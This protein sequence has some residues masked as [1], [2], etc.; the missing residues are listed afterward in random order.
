MPFC[1]CPLRSGSSGN[2]LFVQAGNTR[3][4]VDAGLSGRTVEQA[5]T[6]VG[7]SPDSL[8]AILVSHEHA[9]HIRG[10]GVLSRRYN[11]PVYATEKT[12]LAMETCQGMAGIALRDRRVLGA[13]QD[14]YV[15]DLAVS[16]FSIPHDAAD[17]VG[18]SLHFGGR[19]LCVA[20]DLGHLSLS[21]LTALS[22][23]N[24]ALLEANH[25]PGLLD[26]SVRYPAYLK[27]RILSRNG[28]LS[29]EDCGT[30]VVRLAKRGT[31]HFILGHLSAETNT[32]ALASQTV[33]AA[34]SAAGLK[35]QEDVLVDLAHRDRNA[36]LYTL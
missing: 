2:A 28:H 13:G 26:R 36:G 27:R 17:P 8:N 20:T 30:A 10:V 32:P 15:R 18:Y 19:K 24:L 4:L 12:W 1:F 29:N 7:V 31:R 35:P 14:F 23:A 5:L 11:L 9:D 22:G 3:V 6:E 21:W 33:S 25:D 34:L 16:P